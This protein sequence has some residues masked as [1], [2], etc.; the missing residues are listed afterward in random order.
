MPEVRLDPE[1][2]NL[3]SSF[4]E[5]IGIHGLRPDS[6]G[7]LLLRI[8][9]YEYLM[10]VRPLSGK[11][12]LVRLLMPMPTDE[13]AELKLLRIISEM[14]CFQLSTKGGAIG[15]WNG[16]LYYSVGQPYAAMTPLALETFVSNVI[17]HTT[18]LKAEIDASMEKGKRPDASFNPLDFNYLMFPV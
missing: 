11:I 16:A 2:L 14:N 8:D 5:R 15:V 17:D 4:G 13:I 10:V 6:E 7:M 3:V 9:G 18:S 12:H 1:V